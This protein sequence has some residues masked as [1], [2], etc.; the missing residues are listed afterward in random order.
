MNNGNKPVLGIF[1]YQSME[2]IIK[3]SKNNYEWITLAEANIHSQFSI[4]CL[5][6]LVVYLAKK[7]GRNIESF[8][9]RILC[10]K[11]KVLSSFNELS[12]PII[13]IIWDLSI[14]ESAKVYISKKIKKWKEKMKIVFIAKNCKSGKVFISIRFLTFWPFSDW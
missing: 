11:W 12:K 14:W 5:Q 10:N 4:I 3:N 2:M 7:T 8:A 13:I 1:Y 6:T 9:L